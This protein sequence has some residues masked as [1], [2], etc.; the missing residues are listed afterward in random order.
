MRRPLLVRCWRAPL[1]HRGVQPRGQ[2]AEPSFQRLYFLMLTVYL[3]AKLG[4]GA[5]QERYFCL[6]LFERGVVHGQQV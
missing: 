6:D 4:I 1:G 3:I 5:L 2:F